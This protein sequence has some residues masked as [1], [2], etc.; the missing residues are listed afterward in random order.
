MNENSS[1]NK[2]N[3]AAEAAMARHLEAIRRVTVDHE[4]AYDSEGLITNKLKFMASNCSMVLD[5]GQSTRENVKLFEQRKIESLDINLE[6]PA[7]D[8]IDDICAPSRLQYERYDGIVCLSVLEHVYDP[9]TA[10]REIFRLLQPGG[11]LFLHLPFLFRYHAPQDLSFTDCYRF[12]RDG[13]AWLLRDFSEVTLYSIRGPY[14]SIFNLHRS[15]K[16]G[17]EK[18]LGMAPAR[19]LDRVGMRFFGRPTSE[20]QVSGYYAWAKK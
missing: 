10:T 2:S 9:F 5:I 12:S 20:L 6:E 14:S 15:W 17:V 3:P 18:H 1:P 13:I 19:W 7:A 4:Y 16:K 8:I 11:Y